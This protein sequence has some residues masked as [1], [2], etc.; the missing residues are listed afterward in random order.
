MTTWVGVDPGSR[1]TGICAR[2]GTTL[3]GWRVIDRLEI[4]PTSERPGIHTMEAIVHAVADLAD[5]ATC[6][7][8]VEDMIP[9]NPHVTR[10]NGSSI[11]AVS[12]MLDVRE[13]IGY[14]RCAYPAA[15]L[16]RPDS[17][18]SRTLVSY[19]DGLVTARER[20]YALKNKTLLRP[21]P[22]G[23]FMRHARSA[24]DIAAA[25][26]VAARIQLAM[27]QTGAVN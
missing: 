11:V 16:V 2:D 21:A 5:P 4:E 15:V 17:H 20:A 7:I 24:Y 25:G 6:R 3:H 12:S 14:L 18:G 1:W 8:A 27:S 22:Q 10:K 13:V 26:L 9:P 23:S 19:P